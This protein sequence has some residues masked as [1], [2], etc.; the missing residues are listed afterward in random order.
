MTDLTWSR[1]QDAVSD[2]D[3]LTELAGYDLGNPE[4]RA[5]LDEITART[6]R[7]LDLPIA[8]TTMV[9]DT[10]QLL[11]GSHGL[12][13]WIAAADGTPVEWSFCARAVAAG[14]P[15]VVADAANDPVQRANPLVLHDGVAAYAGYPLTT[16]AGHSLGAHCVISDRPHAFSAEEL[17]I[18]EQGAQQV[19]EVLSR[20]RIA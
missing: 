8:L 13:G 5:Q 19:L 16:P 14:R 11:L 6:C 7:R 9:L 12:A 1:I 3:R 4:L 2:L 17:A 15:Y 20:F 18:I 10:A